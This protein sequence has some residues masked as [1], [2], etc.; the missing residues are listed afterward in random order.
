[1]SELKCLEFV[2]EYDTGHG[3]EHYGPDGW[4]FGYTP[5]DDGRGTA[6]VVDSRGMIAVREDVDG[7]PFAGPV[8]AGFAEH[9]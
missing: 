6:A 2:L 8:Y 9:W 1:M 3:W 5:H 4:V 7:P